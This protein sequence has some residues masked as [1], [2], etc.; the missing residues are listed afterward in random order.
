MKP[1]QDI[2]NNAYF[3]IPIYQRGY[4][5]NEKQLKDLWQDIINLLNSE[6]RLHYMGMLGTEVIPEAEK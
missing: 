2:F 3:R 4:S 5:W 6:N 1:L